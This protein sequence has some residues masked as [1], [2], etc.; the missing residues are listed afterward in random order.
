MRSLHT[1][2]EFYAAARRPINRR[3]AIKWAA[4]GIVTV[5]TTAVILF[6]SFFAIVTGLT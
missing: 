1:D 4:I 6:A 3:Q 5:M 2:L